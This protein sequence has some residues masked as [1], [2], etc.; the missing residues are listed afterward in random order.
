MAVTYWD[1]VIKVTTLRYES[2]PRCAGR[3]IEFTD[4]YGT[5]DICFICGYAGPVKEP[6]PIPAEDLCPGSGQPPKAISWSTTSQRVGTPRCN[7]CGHERYLTD[8]MIS[9]HADER[10]KK[11]NRESERAARRASASSEPQRP[12]T[13]AEG[14]ATTSTRTA[15]K[16]VG[17]WV[18]SIGQ[19]R[20]AK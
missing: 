20:A 10:S 12:Q 3:M 5:D 18:L 7:K 13:S 11:G 15:A 17:G 2:C 6:D 1:R 8:G 16:K 19:G 14:I 9:P 4:I